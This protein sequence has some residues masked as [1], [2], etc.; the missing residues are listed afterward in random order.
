M[1]NKYQTY[2]SLLY[3]TTKPPGTSVDG[4][5]EF[6]KQLVLPIEGKVLEAGVGNGRMLIGFLKYKVNI[7]GVD[8]SKE[9]LELCQNNL[10]KNNLKCELICCDLVDFKKENEFECIIMPNASFNLLETRQKAIQVLS[11]FYTSLQSEGQIALDLIMPVDF[12]AG[13]EHIMEHK[14]ND[15]NLTVKNYS[16]EINWYDQYTINKINYIIDNKIVETQNFKL[17]W[18]GVKEFKTIL[19]QIGFK[20][21][22]IIKNYNNSRVLNLKTITFIATK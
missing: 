20:K 8:K 21:V 4:D 3:D 10:D 11:N 2:S 18:Y 17:N 6:Y 14:I 12:K 15:L 19:E 1:E 22:E 9:M 16:Q 13:S 7:I 5:I